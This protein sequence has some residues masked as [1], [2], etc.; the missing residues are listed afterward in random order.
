MVSGNYYQKP[1]NEKVYFFLH[2]P[3]VLRIKASRHLRKFPQIKNLDR[4][5]EFAHKNKLVYNELALNTTTTEPCSRPFRLKQGSSANGGLTC[6]QSAA[7]IYFSLCSSLCSFPFRIPSYRLR[8][9]GFC[10]E[11]LIWERLSKRYRPFCRATFVSFSRPR[12]TGW[13]PPLTH[14]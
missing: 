11:D 2:I 1:V 10:P 8:A 14:P 3:Q 7:S 6:C 13:P 12:P 9:T 5:R 4:L